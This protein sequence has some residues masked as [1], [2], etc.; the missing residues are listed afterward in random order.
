MTAID[1]NKKIQRIRTEEEIRAALSN[2]IHRKHTMTVPP[3][4]EDDDIVLYDAFKELLQARAWFAR[5]GD[6]DKEDALYFI[7]SGDCH[8]SENLEVLQKEQEA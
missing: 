5:I 4:V 7:D 3:Q 6:K 1:P 8:G 2:L